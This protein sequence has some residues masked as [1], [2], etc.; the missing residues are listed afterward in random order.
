MISD[1]IRAVSPSVSWK[2]A[3]ILKFTKIQSNL[4][5]DES[6]TK[7]RSVERFESG[8]NKSIPKVRLGLKEDLKC[9]RVGQRL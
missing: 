4:F 8:T 3:N 5:N 1:G 9:K 6:E 7:Y 2:S